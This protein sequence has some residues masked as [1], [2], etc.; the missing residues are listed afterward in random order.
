MRR[1]WPVAIAA[2]ILP[3]LWSPGKSIAGTVDDPVC[4]V[5]ADYSLGVEDYPEAIRLH[6]EVLRKHPNNALAHYH[7]GFAQG[8]VGDREA[9]LKEYQQAEALG[10]RDWD[11]FLNMGLAQLANGQLAAA[12]DSLQQ[13]V[14][15]G[16]N[17]SES[18]FNLALAYERRGMLADAERE[19]LVSLRLDPEQPDAQNMLGVIYAQEGK[20]TCASL[21][22]HEILRE[23]PDYQ[24]VRANLAILGSQNEPQTRATAAVAA[25]RAITV[26]AIRTEHDRRFTSVRCTEAPDTYGGSEKLMQ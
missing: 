23:L 7:L 9:E 1:I 18:H 16:G 12:T 2:A 26:K 20:A 17:H 6:R 25:S 8:M 3:L 10:L 19:T 5:G 15:L 14:R 24:P 11:L 4:D 21:L 22:W 13:A